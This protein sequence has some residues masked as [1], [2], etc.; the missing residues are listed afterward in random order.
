M[1]SLGL[2]VV[3]D[4]ARVKVPVLL[5]WGDADPVLPAYLADDAVKQFSGTK[6]DLIRYPDLGHYPM[7]ELPQ[8]T[9]KDLRAWFDKTLAPA[10]TE[11][12]Q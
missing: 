11:P 7:L 12:A 3:D 1:A 4:A 5:Q 2:G 9:A 8:E 6:V 10:A